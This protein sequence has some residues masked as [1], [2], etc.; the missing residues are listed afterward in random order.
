MHSWRYP[1]QDYPAI[2]TE[3]SPKPLSLS[4]G[5][6]PA[7]SR[8]V[9]RTEIIKV[10]PNHKK[11]LFGGVR[12]GG[13][14]ILVGVMWKWN[15][16]S[17]YTTCDTSQFFIFTIFSIYFYKCNVKLTAKAKTKPTKVKCVTMSQHFSTLF[18]SCRFVAV[19]CL[20]CLLFK[21]S[22]KNI[23]KNFAET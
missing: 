6:Y 19:F 13:N 14:T 20:F 17:D 2:H 21:V 16:A 8:A 10:T 1:V 18:C 22:Q 15:S 12:L 3:L 5:M 23:T 4:P 9:D 7:H 11:K